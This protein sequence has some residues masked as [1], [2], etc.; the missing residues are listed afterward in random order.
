MHALSPFVHFEQVRMIEAGEQIFVN[1]GKEYFVDA[2]IIFSGAWRVGS[3]GEVG[4]VSRAR[5]N[6]GDSD[7]REEKTEKETAVGAFAC[8]CTPV[9]GESIKLRASCGTCSFYE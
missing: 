9:S 1:Y 5:V 3:A 6:G 7:R 8:Q 2:L 4:E